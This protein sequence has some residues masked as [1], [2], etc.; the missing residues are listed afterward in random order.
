MIRARAD[1]ADP[2]LAIVVSDEADSYRAE[3]KWLAGQLIR[4]GIHAACVH[5]RDLRFTD[6][7]LFLP[8]HIQDRPISIVY[9]F[10][11]LFDLANIPKH[12]L[13]MYAAKK[14][15]TVVTPP[16]KP[17]LEEK[18]AFALI[19]HPMLEQYWRARLPDETF[20]LLKRLMPANLDTRSTA[21]SA[22]GCDSRFNTGQSSG[23]RLACAWIGKSERASLRRQNPLDFRSWLGEVGASQ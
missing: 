17:W 22:M 18:L 16:Y 11:E 12:E 1:Q 2:T 9:R 20:S 3:M 6:E 15:L 13:I 23:V 21:D 19:H 7:G 14:G 4:E 8:D 5:P 10:F